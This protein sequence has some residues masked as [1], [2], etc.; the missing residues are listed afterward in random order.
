MPRFSVIVPVYKVQAY[1]HDCLESVL[2]QSYPDLELIAVDDRS[3]DACGAII[4]EFAARDP[5]V[6]AGASSGE[7][8]PGR[9][10]QRGDARS[11]RRLPALP[12]RRRH[13]HPGRPAGD[14]RPAEGDGRAGHPG[15]R[16]RTHLLGRPGRPQ[17]GRPPAHRAGPGAVPPGGPPGTAAAADGGLEQ[18]V[19]PGVRRTVGLRLPARPLRGHPVDVP[20]ADGR[21]DDRDPGPGVRAPPTAPAGPSGQHPRLHRPPPLRHLR[22]VRPG[23]RV[24]RGA[25]GTGVLAAGVVPPHGR[26]PGDGV[27]PPRPAP[28]RVPCRVPAR[29]A[30][31]LPPVPRPRPPG[32]PRLPPAARPRPPGPA[33]RVH[34]TAAGVGRA[35]PER[36]GGRPPA[37]GPAS[38]RPAAALP[39]PTAP[40][41]V[42]RPRRVR[43]PRGPRPR[44][45]PGRPGDR[46]PHPRT[47]H[48]HGVDR[49][50]RAPPHHPDRDP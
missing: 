18:G 47:A 15:A 32:T 12:G 19:P 9:C 35:P 22:A 5:R 4:D 6:L 34:G 41:G 30:C 33:P 20:G 42:R 26:S 23:L 37:E 21:R 10:P 27:R 39:R 8:G 43:R 3:P 17:P 25:R 14:R 40:A 29:R 50:P 31:P 13:P 46:V 48:R 11:P 44:L 2:T 1:L 24:S 45:G 38:H 36:Q 49:P 16:P 7:P 28:A